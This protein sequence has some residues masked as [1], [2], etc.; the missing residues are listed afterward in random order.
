MISWHTVHIATQYF[1]IPCFTTTPAY[2]L[3]SLGP[4]TE[5]YG[6]SGKNKLS[7]ISLHL[8]GV[9]LKKW[10]RSSYVSGLIYVL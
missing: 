9:V 1:T 5:V 3:K 2:V 6:R 7:S 4:E 10:V 8:E